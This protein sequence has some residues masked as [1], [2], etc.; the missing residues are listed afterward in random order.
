MGKNGCRYC[1]M[2]TNGDIPD[3]HK[4]IKTKIYNGIFKS[5]SIEVDIFNNMLCVYPSAE[6]GGD[7][8][9]FSAKAPIKYCP[10]CGRKLEREVEHE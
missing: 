4:S 5:F 3:N 9:L 6:W 1:R 8:F 10:M 7:P 2:E